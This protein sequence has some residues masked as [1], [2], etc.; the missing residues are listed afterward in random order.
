MCKTVKWS[1]INESWF[2][3]GMQSHYGNYAL[4]VSKLCDHLHIPTSIALHNLLA[5][6]GVGDS[7]DRKAGK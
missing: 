5:N 4:S 2:Y 7:S 3:V 6:L 1:I